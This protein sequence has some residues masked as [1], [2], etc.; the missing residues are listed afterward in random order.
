M[1]KVIAALIVVLTLSFSSVALA[2]GCPGRLV[3]EDPGIGC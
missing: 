2:D 3:P 1:R